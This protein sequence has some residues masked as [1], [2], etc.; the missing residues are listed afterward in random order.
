MPE[1][2]DIE[3]YARAI[4]AQG[5]NRR[6]AGVDLRD[7]DRLRGSRLADLEAALAGHAFEAVK[8]HG[9][10]LFL[11]VS[12]GWRLVLHFG[13]TGAVVFHDAATDAPRHARLVLRFEDGGHLAFDDQRKLGWLELTDDVAAY[14]RSQDIG[15]DALSFDA[16]GF[17][18]LLAGK[19]GIIKTALTDQSRIAGIGNVYAD[20]VLFQAGV[21][22]DRKAEDLGADEIE[23]VHGKLREVLEQAAALDADPARMPDDWL[24]PRRGGEATCPRCGGALETPKLSGR[25]AYLCPRCQ[26]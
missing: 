11:T 22:P 6:I 21:R 2:P 19:R 4:R 26:T 15:P 7:P 23:A 14:L 12:C 18:D 3:A 8:R 20:E 25:T 1:L 13:M 9:K 17:R 5:L 24:T 16:A 10:M